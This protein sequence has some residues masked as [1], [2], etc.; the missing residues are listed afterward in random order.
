MTSRV[1]SMTR[2]PS[3]SQHGPLALSGE[4]FMAERHDSSLSRPSPA[5]YLIREHVNSMYYPNCRT[6]RSAV[7]Y[8]ASD[9]RQLTRFITL[10]PIIPT[11]V[12]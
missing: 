6:H 9:A 2:L 4:N 5:W 11:K 7:A 1:K 10:G 3:V 12:A 8:Y